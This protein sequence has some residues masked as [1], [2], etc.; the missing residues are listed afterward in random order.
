MTSGGWQNRDPAVI[1]AVYEV[2]KNLSF[3][4]PSVS[5]RYPYHLDRHTGKTFLFSICIQ[6]Q[7]Q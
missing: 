5:K 1:R 6:T 4:I 7:T 2:L 3:E